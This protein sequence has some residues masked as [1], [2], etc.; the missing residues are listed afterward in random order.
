MRPLLLVLLVLSRFAVAEELEAPA[1]AASAAKPA[2]KWSLD[3]NGGVYAGVVPSDLASRPFTYSYF[4]VNLVRSLGNRWSVGASS[5]VEVNNVGA[6]WDTLALGSA[7]YAPKSWIS[8]T[9]FAGA[10]HLPHTANAITSGVV[11][12]VPTPWG[13]AVSLWLAGNRYSRQPNV[14]VQV[15]FPIAT[16]AK[17]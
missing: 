4:S 2:P 12:S 11:V 15:S 10:I 8:L 13:P 5:M 7:T 14:G 3:L 16:L 17:W 9:G 6:D 1:A